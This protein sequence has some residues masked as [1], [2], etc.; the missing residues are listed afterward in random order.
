MVC[1]DEQAALAARRDDRAGLRFATR[2]G[3]VAWPSGKA[4]AGA[5]VAPDGEGAFARAR[6]H[7]A[8][9]D[10]LD[11]ARAARRDAEE[12][13]AAASAAASAAQEESL[14]AQQERSRVSGLLS[15]AT[16][17]ARSAEKTL[18]RR[19]ADVRDAAARR[20]EAR[21]AL[22]GAAPEA[23]RHEA[24]LAELEEAARAAA[25]ALAAAQDAVLPAREEEQR[26]S[27]ALSEA[28]LSEATLAERVDFAKRSLA[29]AER[30]LSAVGDDDAAA[31]RSLAE[32]A[33]VVRRAEPLRAALERVAERARAHAALLERRAAD[34]LAAAEG[35]HARSD[36]ARAKAKAAREAFD[37]A[38]ERLS[39]A[40]VEKS[41]LAVRVEA[42]VSA[43]VSDCDTP[44]E[45]ALALP[46]LS[47]RAAVEDAAFRLRRRI[48]SMG[49][50]NPDAAAE[51]EQMKSRHDYLAAQLSDLDSAR[52][53]L[54]KIDRVIDERM[55]GDFLTAFMQI[56]DNFKEIF[57][58]LFPGGSAELSLTDPD[59]VENTGV[60]VSAQPRGKRVA[61]MSLL[62]GGEKSL[63][64]IALL[65][66]AYR[67]RSAPFY[68]LDEVEA[69]L[70]DTNLRR[71]T[72]YFQSLR[73]TT[74]L[75]LITHQR[76]TMEMAD[77]LF[78]VTMQA[79]G[80]T[81]VVS[82]RLE[83][84]LRLTE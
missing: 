78:G 14:A 6:Q 40:R 51:Y 43:I 35:T 28:R 55:K 9:V 54:E 56:N 58:T 71:L 67:I 70:D 42:G 53:A 41:G 79:D 30:E 31:R 57:A 76:R 29:A 18:A 60:E 36:E 34:A 20:D 21:G 75:V 84:A 5:R 68:I 11:A 19:E 32:Q 52:T 64:A 3:F 73:E 10:A 83:G 82:Q 45:E 74:Q 39:A 25:A 2:T 7:A 38:S 22:E 80:V 16:G 1:P 49:A 63:V 23:V 15:A 37:L 4:T 77:V 47:D 61:K 26:A 24:E 27:K 69:A 72:G 50:V 66:A 46:E 48:A 8:A 33:V 44:L 17:A 12:R 62:S 81:K 59:D 13:L 65:F